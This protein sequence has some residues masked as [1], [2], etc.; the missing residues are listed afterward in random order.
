ME[1][2]VLLIEFEG[3]IAETA[4]ARR[5]ALAESLAVE[6]IAGTDAVLAAGAGYATED[7]VRRARRAAGAPDDETAVELG[8]LRAERAFAT[9]AGKGL[10]L[11]R[12]ARMA[13]ERLAGHTRLALVTR[14]SR[15]EV[16]FLLGLAGMEG[17]F[18][19]IIG[20]EEVLPTKPAREPWRAA[21]ARIG[22]LFPGQQLKALAV[23]DHVVGLRA[24]RAAGLASVGVGPMPAHEALE[25]DAW[26]ESLADLTPERVRAL[27][28]VSTERRR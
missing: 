19:P 21:L 22:Q 25:G 7:A 8:R 6:G 5:A 28:G 3:V 1:V 18:R 24:A 13:L 12:D 17:L 27:L 2:P 15:R 11:T 23:E 20:C 14:A 16:E 9:R 4:A 10:P 26:V